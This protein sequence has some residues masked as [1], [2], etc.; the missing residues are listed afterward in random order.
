MVDYENAAKAASG[1]MGLLPI[2]LIVLLIL[3]C[4]RGVFWGWV[5]KKIIK[6][7]GYLENWFCWGFFFGFLAMVIALTKPDVFRA[8]GGGWDESRNTYVGDSGQQKEEQPRIS[9]CASCGKQVA[10]GSKFCVYCGAKAKS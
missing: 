1:G 5:V 2:L 10:E 8:V 6:N 7:K 3:Y 9:Y 4:L